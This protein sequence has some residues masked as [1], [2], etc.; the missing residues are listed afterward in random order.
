[1]LEKYLNLKNIPIVKAAAELGVSRPYL[2]DV[3]NGKRFPSRKLALK[4]ES[5]SGGMVPVTHFGYIQNGNH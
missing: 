1:M 4:I 5:W 2:T 3:K